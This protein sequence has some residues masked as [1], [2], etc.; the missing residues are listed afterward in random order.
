[1]SDMQQVST[2][3]TNELGEYL[4]NAESRF[5]EETFSAAECSLAMQ[6]C[7]QEWYAFKTLHVTFH[8]FLYKIA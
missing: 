5:M 8:I 7:L 2:D 1:M 3:A 6:N 4:Q